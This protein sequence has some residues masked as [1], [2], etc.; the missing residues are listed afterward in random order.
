MPLPK[1]RSRYVR[2][3]NLNR[4]DDSRR[5]RGFLALMVDKLT[6]TGVQIT[7]DH[8]T[9]AGTQAEASVTFDSVPSD[10]DIITFT[11]PS[12][13]QSYLFVNALSTE[14]DPEGAYIEVLIDDASGTA[15]AANFGQ[16]LAQEEAD[17][18]TWLVHGQATGLPEEIELGLVD[19]ADVYIRAVEPGVAGNAY[20][21]AKTN[22]PDLTLSGATFAGGIEPGCIVTT[23]PHG[24]ITGDGP[25]SLAG[26]SL[27]WTIDTVNQLYYVIVL[28]A[29]TFRL[30]PTPYDAAK[31]TYFT[32]H[33]PTIHVGDA[34]KYR[35]AAE[36]IAMLYEQLRAGMTAEQ[37]VLATD[38]D[39]A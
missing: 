39:P 1:V 17:P 35:L 5:L 33:R 22:G 34:I 27:S 38:I 6:G 32:L 12:G 20:T 18:A 4:L 37:L 15:S 11:T 7:A 21:I 9:D 28:D 16:A 30:A 13:E 3:G 26:S 25:I 8:T 19:T 23:D 14:V 31:G 24:F 36:S 10:G 29:N 2:H